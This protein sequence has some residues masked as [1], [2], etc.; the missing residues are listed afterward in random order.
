MFRAGIVKPLLARIFPL[1][2][3]RLL[4]SMTTC[5]REGGIHNLDVCS[6]KNM[7]LFSRFEQLNRAG[8]GNQTN[9][10]SHSSV[11]LQNASLVK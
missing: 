2:S 6:F 3:R 7:S 8:Y 9:R 1:E 10:L 11:L 4:I 5:Q